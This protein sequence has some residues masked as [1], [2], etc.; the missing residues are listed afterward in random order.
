MHISNFFFWFSYA[1]LLRLLRCLRNGQPVLTCILKRRLGQ[2]SGA[3]AQ[4]LSI[5]GIS[6]V[7]S[8]VETDFKHFMKQILQEQNPKNGWTGAQVENPDA[9]RGTMDH[10]DLIHMTCICLLAMSLLLR[11]PSYVMKM[12]EDLCSQRAD[13]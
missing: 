2:S 8:C 4:E 6:R 10:Y 5:M 3:V 1:S 12:G 13:E 9:P 11:S 7:G